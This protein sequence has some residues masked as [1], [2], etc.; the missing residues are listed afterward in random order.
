MVTLILRKQK[1]EV[2][3]GMTLLDALKK[4]NLIPEGIIA[5]REGELIEE[6]ELLRDGETIIL[7]SAIS[8]G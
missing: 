7:I 8:G 2:R 5:T 6:D 3:A 4:N 1:F